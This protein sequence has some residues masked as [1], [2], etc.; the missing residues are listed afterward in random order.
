MAALKP[1]RTVIGALALS[2]LS[3]VGCGSNRNDEAVDTCLKAA[4][5]KL[6]DKR[7]ELDRKDMAAHVVQESADTVFITTPATFDQGLSSQYKQ[8][9]ECRVRFETGKP[10]SVIWLQFAWNKEDL[11]KAD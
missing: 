3:F 10:P 2:T 7:Y 9:F 5:D 8:T 11:K 1:V 4:A 6:A